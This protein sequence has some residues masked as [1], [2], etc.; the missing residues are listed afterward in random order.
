M[1]S[2]AHYGILAEEVLGTKS[3][4]CGNSVHKPVTEGAPLEERGSSGL[5][6][7]AGFVR[8][9]GRSQG[10]GEGILCF[11][12]LPVSTSLYREVVRR[13]KALG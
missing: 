3:V 6:V 12:T 10:L 13:D 1:V 11:L 5:G 2:S 4:G 7:F 9:H 8:N